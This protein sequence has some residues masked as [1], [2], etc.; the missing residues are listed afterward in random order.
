MIVVQDRPALT[1]VLGVVVW[2][3]EPLES[4]LVG[5]R[6]EFLVPDQHDEAA[7]SVRTARILRYDASKGSKPGGQHLV[8]YEDSSSSSSKEEDEEEQQP[9]KWV[10]L[11]VRRLRAP[12]I[13]P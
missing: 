8:A 5:R 2:L 1:S 13:H 3:A 7:V 11:K 6:V 10:D 12:P 4:F 9:P